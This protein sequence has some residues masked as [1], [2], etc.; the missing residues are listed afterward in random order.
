MQLFAYGTWP[1]YVRQSSAIASLSVAQQRK[2][3]V[4]TIASLAA[5][6][7]TL[8]YQELMAQLDLVSI[9]ELEDLIISDCIYTGVVQGRLD[10]R[11]RCLH[12]EH[13]LARDVPPE[14]LPQLIQSL[15]EWLDNA[16][17]VMAGIEAQVQATG[18]A[19]AATEARRAARQKAAEAEL[20]SVRAVL[21][22]RAQHDVAA[23]AMD[24]GDAV[25]LGGEGSEGEAGP[26]GPR[27][28]KRRR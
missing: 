15:D 14:G 28:T 5:C 6:R 3:K 22:A 13:A 23:M 8:P 18:E 26:S 24:E 16:Q 2:L 25:A 10:Q 19:V 7:R 27:L 17:Q 12:V 1:D 20:S 9:R 21:E 4:L 11:A